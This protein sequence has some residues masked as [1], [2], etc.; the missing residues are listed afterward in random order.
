MASPTQMRRHVCQVCLLELTRI[1]PG[2][3]SVASGLQNLNREMLP[4]YYKAIQ[5]QTIPGHLAANMQQPV[6]FR[7]Y[8]SGPMNFLAL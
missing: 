5:Q 6:V 2:K 1:G 3:R 8:V 4:F 7:A